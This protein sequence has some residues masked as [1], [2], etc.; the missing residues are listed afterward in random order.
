[1]G[2]LLVSVEDHD[3]VEIRDVSVVTNMDAEEVDETLDKVQNDGKWSDY[4]AKK[5]ERIN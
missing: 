3:D 5:N 1:V 2:F 4:N